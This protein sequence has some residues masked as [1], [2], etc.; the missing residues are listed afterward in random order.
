MLRTIGIRYVI[1]DYDDGAEHDSSP[2]TGV[3]NGLRASG[4]I[5]S[6]QKLPGADAFELQGLPGDVR[7]DRE[8]PW[9][10]VPRN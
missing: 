6:E 4:Q 3:V 5:A 2:A 8:V 7:V 10:Q 1:V 9:S